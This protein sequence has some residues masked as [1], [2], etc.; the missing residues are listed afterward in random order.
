MD[1]KSI[2]KS[3]DT[4]D[5]KIEGIV[6]HLLKKYIIKNELSHQDIELKEE[7]HCEQ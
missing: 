7:H 6:L 2:E 1:N 4:T 5:D 3:F